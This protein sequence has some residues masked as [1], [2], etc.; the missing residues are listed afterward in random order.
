MSSF[1]QMLKSYRTWRIDGFFPIRV[2]EAGLMKRL[3]GQNS[4]IE[5]VPSWTLLH[6]KEMDPALKS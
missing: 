2:T 1:K 4:S 3:Q 5:G 6:I